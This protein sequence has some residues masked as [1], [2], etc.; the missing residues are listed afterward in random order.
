M[1]TFLN[2]NLFITQPVAGG[3]ANRL[4]YANGTIQLAS[5]AGLTFDGT[6]FS[7]TAGKF[8]DLSDTNEQV[9][10]G[11]VSTYPG[12]WLGENTI[13]PATTNAA[14]L[15]DTSSNIT[16]LNTP[17]GGSLQLRIGNTAFFTAASAISLLFGS[18]ASSGST[19]PQLLSLG[20]TYGTNAA[21]SNNNMKLAIYDSGGVKYGFTLSPSL[22]TMQ[23]PAGASIGF[24]VNQTAMV[25]IDSSG[26]MG[27]GT[28]GPTSYLHLKAGTTAASSS[29]LKFVS[30]SLMTAAEALAVEC[31][32]DKLYFTITTGAARKELTL[33]DAALTSTRIPFATTNGRLTDNSYLTFNSGTGT[34]SS[35][36]LNTGGGLFTVDQDGNASTWTLYT[37][38]LLEVGA[39][40]GGSNIS[41]ATIN[42][43]GID[44][45]IRANNGSVTVAALSEGGCWQMYDSANDLMLELAPGDNIIE[46]RQYGGGSCEFQVSGQL[47]AMGG[48]Y[49]GDGS[50]WIGFTSTG[51]K[52]GTATNQK[53]GF[54]NA[55]PIVQPTTA[56]AAAT[57]VA[58]AGTAVN[59]ASTFDGYT[60]KQV[61]KALRNIGLMA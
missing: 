6:T 29:P 1:G 44:P 51:N 19:T 2:P 14:L 52:I 26:R 47:I 36:A 28:T 21:G 24:Y 13:T 58:G 38:S 46:V 22:M 54:W 43:D 60:L 50:N 11:E 25:R 59:D 37:S 31:L 7:A 48:M 32:T 12:V 41:W 10:L 53:F 17:S 61:V 20:G 56:V 35:L 4:L 34:L 23:V 49:V 30:G 16:V 5:S 27:I 57:F 33:N 40:S 8:G 3:S 42:G 18:T 9:F 45:Y 15:Y 55:T 39:N